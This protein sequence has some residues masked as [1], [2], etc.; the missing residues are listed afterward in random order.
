MIWLVIL[1]MLVIAAYTAAVCVKQGGVPA[2]ISAT[3]Y[4]LEHKHWFMVTTWFTAWLLMPAILEV[5]KPDTEFLAFLSCIGMLMVGVAPNFKD[6]FEGK[7]HTAGAILCIAGSQLWVACNCP[8]CLTVWLAYIIYTLAMMPRHVSDSIITDFL[9]TKPMFW[10]EIA[11]LSA[12][13][14]SILVAGL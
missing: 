3:F 7:V 6:E 2:S 13:Y 1:S 12:T 11:A 14:A 4:K 8:W 9:R 10:I 5:S